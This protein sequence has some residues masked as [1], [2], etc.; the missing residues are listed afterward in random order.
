MNTTG[1]QPNSLPGTAPEVIPA[2]SARNAARRRVTFDH[3]AARQSHGQRRGQSGRYG[4]P[5]YSKSPKPTSQP[6]TRFGTAVPLCETSG[7]CSVGLARYWVWLCPAAR[8]AVGTMRAN[9]R[10]VMMWT[11]VHHRQMAFRVNSSV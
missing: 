2:W 4:W 6:V 3:A 1:P 11:L 7:A 10:I 5:S 8:C 9:S